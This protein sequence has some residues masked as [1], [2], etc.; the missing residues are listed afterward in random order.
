[1]PPHSVLG[2]K[3]HRNEAPS[4]G[5]VSSFGIPGRAPSVVLLAHRIWLPISPYSDR[6]RSALR[7]SRVRPPSPR[8]FGTSAALELSMSHRCWRLDRLGWFMDITL[9]RLSSRS[10]RRGPII[11]QDAS[12]N[13]TDLPTPRRRIF[14]C[15]CGYCRIRREPNTCSFL[16]A[17]SEYGI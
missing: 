2:G 14:R 3:R 9:A 15:P 13:G 8:R 4:K 6:K 11:L 17:V 7:R 12:V 10:A 1:M 16:A 5:R